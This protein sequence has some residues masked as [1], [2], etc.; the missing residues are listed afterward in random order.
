MSHSANEQ[1]VVVVPSSLPLE[2]QEEIR[3]VSSRV[4]LCLVAPEVELPPSVVDAAVFYRSWSLP[5]RTVDAIVERAT[6]LRWMHVPSAGV[7]IALTP[8]VLARDFIIT[9]MVGVYDQPVAEFALA[10]ILAAAKRLPAYVR[11]QES[12]QW[13]GVGDWDEVGEGSVVPRMLRGATV[14][15]V[16]Y[17]G[18]GR[19]L[20]ELVRPFQMRVLVA[21]RDP[22][23]EP[24]VAGTYGPDRLDD[25]LRESD[26]VVLALPLTPETERCIGAEQIALMRPAA[27]LVNVGRGRLV[28]DDAL[29]EA[30][31]QRRIAGACL[32]VF[33]RE[34]LPA[35]HPYYA[36]PNVI[37]TPHVAG[38]FP[39]LNEIDRQVFVTQLRRF[40]AGQPLQGVV[41]RARQY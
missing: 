34:P 1:M 15:I 12:A 33:T 22:Q 18:I 31:Q 9:H 32:A 2:L 16:G 26:Y 40:V 10:L 3:A 11:A 17:G 21:R 5:R 36:L 30:L 8:N 6:G 19:A 23:P 7:D 28:D 37:L 27:W 25:L 41:D 39:G 4:E 24:A 38:A 13:R 35:S 29:V 14:G 20:A